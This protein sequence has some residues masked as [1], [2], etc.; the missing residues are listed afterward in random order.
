MHDLNVEHMVA[1]NQILQYIK[2]TIDFGLHLYKSSLTSLLSYID[3]DIGEDVRTPTLTNSN[4]DAEY[5]DVANV[6]FESCWI[7]N[8]Y[9]SQVDLSLKQPLSIVIIS[10]LYTSQ[11]FLSALVR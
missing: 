4:I 1:L 7:H 3:V 2:G 6:V 11:V 9:L 8:C 10:M 5:K